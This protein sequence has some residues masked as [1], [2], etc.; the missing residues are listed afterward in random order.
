MTG[1]ALHTIQD[2]YAHSYGDMPLAKYKKNVSKYYGKED[3]VRANEFHLEWAYD[4][5]AKKNPNGDKNKIKNDREELHSKYKD[6]PDMDFDYKTNTWVSVN[7]DRM[8]N[9]RYHNA[10]NA[11]YVYLMKA[12]KKMKII[13]G[14]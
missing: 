4:Y 14:K 2:Y 3:Y 11:T 9:T 12:L 10:C 7:G 8:K 13:Q 6:N 5:K 1:V